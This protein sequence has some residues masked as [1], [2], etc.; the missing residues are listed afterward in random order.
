MLTRRRS[1]PNLLS[2][3]SKVVKDSFGQRG[4]CPLPD[5]FLLK[6]LLGLNRLG[7]GQRPAIVSPNVDAFSP[8]LSPLVNTSISTC[9]KY[10]RSLL[11]TSFAE[12]Q[13]EQR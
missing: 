7:R 8:V 3:R 6:Q 12:Y 4:R 2:R 13:T 11:G 5:L 9:A 1:R 10:A